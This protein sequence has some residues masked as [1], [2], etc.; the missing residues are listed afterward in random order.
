MQN[1]KLASELKEELMSADEE[2]LGDEGLKILARPTLSSHEKVDSALLSEEW[3]ES[4]PAAAWD[5]EES[6]D[7]D[8]LAD[9][10]LENADV[11]EIKEWSITPRE[12]CVQE[13][14]EA[15]AAHQRQGTDCGSSEV[16]IALFTARIKHITD[17]VISNPKDHASRRGLLALVSKRRRLIN[18]LYSRNAAKAKKLTDDLGIRFR[19]KS[20][21]PDRTEKYRQYTIAANKKM[22]R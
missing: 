9:F 2:V 18:Y 7:E 10:D 17:H 14:T 5:T 4:L 21:M 19:F 1:L 8:L 3:K 13:R 16:Q 11:G 15:K 6:F 22:K 20:S 12:V